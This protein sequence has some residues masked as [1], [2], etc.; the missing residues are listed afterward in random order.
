MRTYSDWIGKISSPEVAISAPQ[1]FLKW[2]AI[3][4]VG[5]ALGRKCWFN[6]GSFR[7]YPNFFICLVG[8]PASGKGSAINFVYRDIARAL[9]PQFEGNAR[10]T[11]NPIN[12]MRGTITAEEMMVN[13]A[14]LGDKTHRDLS[15]SLEELFHDGSLTLITPELGTFINREAERLQDNLTEFWDCNDSFEYRTKTQ[16][17]YTLRGIYL[18]WLAG[19]TPI[20]F[21]NKLPIDAEGQGL[22]SRILVISYSGP[23]FEKDITYTEFPKDTIKALREDLGEIANMKGEF[24]LTDE[25]EQLL[26]EWIK[27]MA[28]H[29][30]KHPK[31]TTY[32]GRRD[33]QLVK[34]CMVMA[35]S[36]SS[37]KIIEWIDVEKAVETLV[38]AEGFMGEILDNFS[39]SSFGQNYQQVLRGLKQYCNDDGY[40]SSSELY[41]K[42]GGV[43]STYVMDDVLLQMEKA[44]M[45]EKSSGI[46][47]LHEKN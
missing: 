19:A 3:S 10:F 15:P 46:L 11:K 24:K 39:V 7:V 17:S 26:R 4:A 41:R 23:D 42:L 29:Q 13:M 12:I 34:L 37:K 20:S 8:E 36:R 30:P 22:L 32:N 43:M 28:S 6:R 1:I 25:A 18:N 38:E 16:G 44:Q 33:T 47:R 2:A 5:A 14:D 21:V 9:T 31:L 35:A 45:I 27:T 40:V